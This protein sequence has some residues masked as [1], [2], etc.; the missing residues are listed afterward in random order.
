[1][2]TTERYLRAGAVARLLH[3]S[4]K[5]VARWAKQGKLPHV[6]TLG[7]HRRFSEEFIRQLVERLT[8]SDL[9]VGQILEGMRA[10]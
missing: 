8:H 7:G 6:R 10:A 1:M 5:T 9:T 4:P 3:V 2:D